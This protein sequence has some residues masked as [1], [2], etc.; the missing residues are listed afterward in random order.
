MTC[1][2][3][4]ASKEIDALGNGDGVHVRNIMEVPLLDSLACQSEDADAG[5]SGLEAS[6]VTKLVIDGVDVFVRCVEFRLL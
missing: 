2:G 4:R 1:S 5:L 3:D 6:V